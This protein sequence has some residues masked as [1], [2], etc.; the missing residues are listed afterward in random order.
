MVY[1]LVDT[2]NS[3][4]DKI[5][6]VWVTLID[7]KVVTRQQAPDAGFRYE[8]LLSDWPA[9]YLLGMNRATFLSLIGEMP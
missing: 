1:A 3:H 9:L 7:E 4:V 2:H 8:C 6:N 5:C